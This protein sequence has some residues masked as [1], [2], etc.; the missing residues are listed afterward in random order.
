MNIKSTNFP[1]TI[2]K[3]FTLLSLPALLLMGALS[4]L[5]VSPAVA[6]KPDCAANPSHPSCK[7]D[8][9]SSD[10]NPSGLDFCVTVHP[11][12]DGINTAIRSDK[13]GP[14]G[15]VDE[16][17][18]SNSDKVMAIGGTRGF[19]F[20]TDTGG[21]ENDARFVMIN[22]SAYAPIHGEDDSFVNGDYE[23]DFRFI[24]TSI[25]GQLGL[26]LVDL[27]FGDTNCDNGTVGI[28]MHFFRKNRD[29][30]E[31]Q[32]GRLGY[33]E[34]E[35]FEMD[36]FVVMQCDFE[37]IL[38]ATVIRLD[39]ITWTVESTPTP[40]AYGFYPACVFEKTKNGSFIEASLLN[41]LL[42]DMPFNFTLVS[43]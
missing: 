20:D 33:G 32:R 16:Y 40:D 25:S 9:D 10:I 29:K 18:P 42:I 24:R 26:P 19:R 22:F 35:H 2:C 1:A 21:K 5:G 23:I 4:L 39:E 30:G 34:L 43:Q 17:C 8:D 41:G 11:E 13:N 31:E 15:Y 3:T 12:I 37:A 14:D 36:G 28:G 38:N 6:A 7:D 27:C